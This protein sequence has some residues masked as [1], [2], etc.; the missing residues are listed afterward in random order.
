MVK[1]IIA[2]FIGRFWS[3][4]SSFLFIPLYIHFLGFYSYSII[5]FTLV[6]ARLMSILDGGLTATLSRELARSDNSHK[7]K[8]KIFKTIESTYFI[9]I[10]FCIISAFCLSGVI[11][12]NWLILSAF[13]PHRVT[14]FLRIISF[15][16][17]FQL[18]LSFYLGGL[19]GLE[20]QVEANI[21]QMSWGIL[22][23]GLVIVAIIFVPSLE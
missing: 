4:L 13:D 12:N 5:S 19:L 8:I 9:I 2:N 3:I 22:R 7:E 23:N 6:I 15:D 16:I 1:N 10:G 11:A 17:G 18:L 14:L 21:Y 20:K